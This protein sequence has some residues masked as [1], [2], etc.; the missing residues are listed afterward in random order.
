MLSGI[1]PLKGSEAPTPNLC[2][3][4]GHPPRAR[5]RH[6]LQLC[7]ANS[8]RSRSFSWKLTK[9]VSLL[10]RIRASEK[11]FRSGGERVKEVGTPP[12]KKNKQKTTQKKP[13]TP[14]SSSTRG[15]KDTE[16]Q[17]L[18]ELLDAEFLRAP[19]PGLAA[20]A[21]L[22]AANDADSGVRAQ[23]APQNPPLCP[24]PTPRTGFSS[25]SS[26]SSLVKSRRQSMSVTSP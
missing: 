8:R 14:P 2:P 18:G 13:Q 17:D 9:V 7:A 16:H 25:P 26:T 24:H 10:A 15:A 1:T 20:A 4:P 12:K 19:R 21:G 5:P 11:R 6:S 23:P 3:L 22:R